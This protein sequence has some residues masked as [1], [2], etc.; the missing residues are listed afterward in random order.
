MRRMTCSDELPDVRDRLHELLKGWQ[1]EIEAKIP[2]ENPDFEPWQE[3]SVWETNRGRDR[4]YLT[5]DT[6]YGRFY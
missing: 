2:E 1:E 3:R 6:S 4:L 5:G